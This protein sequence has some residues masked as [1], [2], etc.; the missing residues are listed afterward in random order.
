MYPVIRRI[1]FILLF[2][3]VPLL[4]FSQQVYHGVLL[5]SL[6]MKPVYDA[7]VYSNV[8]SASFTSDESGRFEIKTDKNSKKVTIYTDH[9][10]YET[11]MIS[12]HDRDT[13]FLNERVFLLEEVV[14]DN[15]SNILDNISDA[16]SVSHVVERSYCEDFFFRETLKENDNYINFIEAVGTTNVLK[17]GHKSIYIKAKRQTENYAEAFVNFASNIHHV[18]NKVSAK[19]VMNSKAINHEKIDDNTRRLTIKS[20]EN[21]RLYDIYVNTDTNRI[22]KMISND[23]NNQFDTKY[24]SQKIFYG[25][26]DLRFDVYKQGMNIEAYFKTEDGKQYIDKIKYEFK[27]CLFNRTKNVKLTYL[28]DK[29]YISKKIDTQERN[30]DSLTHL[31]ERA[32]FFQKKIN[33]DYVDWEEEN[34]YLPI[35]IAVLDGFHWNQ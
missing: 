2:F 12:F 17:S 3:T 5:D 14:L 10:G 13:I 19:I 18:F 26:Q 34:K 22:V 33:N 23:L 31:T 25:G 27:V 24:N 28:W 35:D 11:K 8:T 6:T 16:V 20:G 32:N 30:L 15:L 7:V 21:D 1:T 4:G 29:E 9:I